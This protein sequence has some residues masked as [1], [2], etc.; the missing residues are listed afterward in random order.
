MPAPHPSP[1]AFRVADLQRR[2]RATFDLRPDPG[3]LETL[4]HEL[5]LLG[6]RKLTFSGEVLQH[7]RED[8]R[9]DATLGATVVQPCGITLEPVTTRIDT[10][11]TRVYQSDFVQIDAPEVEMPEDDTVEALGDWID[12]EAVMREALML[13]LPLYPRA[14]GAALGQAIYTEPGKAPMADEDARPFAGLA[15]LRSRLDP[16]DGNEGD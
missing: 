7:D 3:S 1:H 4:A 9:L 14:P 6:L 12:P 10:K 11:V 2:Q 8:W 5:G 16:D 15:A 13:A